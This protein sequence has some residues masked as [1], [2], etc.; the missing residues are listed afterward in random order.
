MRT[1]VRMELEEVIERVRRVVDVRHGADA[2]LAD[3]EASLGDLRVIRAFC[4]AAEADLAGRI[5]AGSSFPESTIAAT[6]RESL[7]AASKTLERA[8]TLDAVP[9]LAEA[10][11]EATVTA[12]HVDVVTRG[13]KGLEPEQRERLYDRVGDLIDIAATATVGQFGRRIRTEITRIVAADGVER[14]ERQRRETRLNTWVGGDGMWN[15]AG[16]FDPVTGLKMAAK[17]DS[18]VEALFAESTPS[19]CP[20]DPVEK[21]RHLRALALAQL[22]DGDGRGRAARG[23]R[24][25]FV[26][27]IDV[28]AGPVTAGRCN[29]T[30]QASARPVTTAGDADGEMRGPRVTWPIPIE[31]PTDVLAD[32]VDDAEVTAVVVCD[33]VV[34]HAPGELD[35]GR[36]TRLANRAQ[37]RALRGLYLTCAIPGCATSYDRCKLHHVVWWRHGGRTDLDN[38]LPVCSKHHHKIHD[39]DWEVTLGPHRELTLALPDG[40]VRSNGP[41]KR[42]AA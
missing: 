26:A 27:V 36:S 3:L 30:D 39:D 29:A 14:L 13:A 8:E 23:G 32:L 1:L 28:A 5:A 6:S 10:L 15:I 40:T 37:R 4:D 9:A 20:P 7:S 34:L 2:V 18:A 17:L 25:E 31:V 38:L 24:P 41:P 19:S 22:V 21:Q 16:R 33:G 42:D 35:L 11:D 12:G